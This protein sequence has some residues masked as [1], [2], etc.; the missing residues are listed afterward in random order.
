MA[1]LIPTDTWHRERGA[2]NIIRSASGR[3]CL[4]VFSATRFVG[5]MSDQYSELSI[6][7]GCVKAATAECL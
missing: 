5:E 1:R 7:C 2:V 3:L 6:S 4:Q